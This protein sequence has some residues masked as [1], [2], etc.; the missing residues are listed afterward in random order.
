LKDLRLLKKKFRNNPYFLLLRLEML[1]VNNKNVL[2]LPVQ[3]KS[4]RR[5]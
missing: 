3:A 5:K 1:A 4:E 2:S